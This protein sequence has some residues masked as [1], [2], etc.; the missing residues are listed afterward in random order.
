MAKELIGRL[1]RP[2]PTEVPT[3]PPSWFRRKWIRWSCKFKAII[4]IIKE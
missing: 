1:P 2:E 4:N 3:L